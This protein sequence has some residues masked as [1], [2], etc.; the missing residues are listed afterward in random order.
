MAPYEALYGLKCRTPLYWIHL[1]EKKIHEVDLIHETEEKVKVIQDSLKAA[2]DR[3][4]SYVDLK[5]KEIEF[6]VG[7]KIFLKVLPWKKVLRFDRKGKL[8]SRFI[9]PYE[10]IKRIRAIVHRLALLPK[11]DRIHNVFHISMLRRY[12]S[13]PSHVI[14]ST[15]V[16]IQ[17]QMTYSKELIKILVHEMKELINKKVAL[18][19]VLW[20]RHGIEEVTWK[21]E[22]I[23]RKQYPKLFTGVRQVG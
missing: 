13:D 18:V 11:I 4:K 2:S 14:S 12:W 23:M 10:I 6:Q 8:S 16:K 5:R 1:S 17:P 15:E 21:L 9:G 3:Q 20:Q 22:E 19:Q 7:D